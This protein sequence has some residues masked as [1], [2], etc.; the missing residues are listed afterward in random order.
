MLSALVIVAAVILYSA[1]ASASS[2]N[3]GVLPK[4][5]DWRTQSTAHFD[6]YYPGDLDL[7]AERVAQEAERAYVHVSQDMRHSL[8]SRV[9]IYL[10]HSGD[11]LRQFRGGDERVLFVGQASHHIV[12]AVDASADQWYGT[13]THEL[14]HVFEFDIVSSPTAPWVFEGLAE[15]ERGEWEPKDLSALRQAVRANGIPNISGL[16]DNSV[17]GDARL[18]YNLGHAAFD[19]IEMRWGKPG[20]REFMMSLRQGGNAYQGGLHVSPSQF[21]QE[22]FR[23]LRGRLR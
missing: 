8:A 14:T 20:V 7:Y 1:P 21:D 22:F 17:N 16:T 12:F 2:Q 23:Y 10:F 4:V 11:E 5:P 19:F 3:S 13:L 9:P 6:V 15:Y 18:V